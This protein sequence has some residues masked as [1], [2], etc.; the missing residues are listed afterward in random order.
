MARDS[1]RQPGVLGKVHAAINRLGLEQVNPASWAA[2]REPSNVASACLDANI[3]HVGVGSLLM[4]ANVLHVLRGDAETAREA[5]WE[6]LSQPVEENPSASCLLRSQAIIVVLSHGCNLNGLCSAA[7]AAYVALLSVEGA[8]QSW[9]TLFQPLAFQSAMSGLR[10]LQR[11]ERSPTFEE[12]GKDLPADDEFFDCV[13]TQGTTQHEAAELLLRLLLVFFR[14]RPLQSSHDIAALAIGELSALVLQPKEDCI[15]QTA[16]DVLVAVLDGAHHPEE[17]RRIAIVILRSLLPALLMTSSKAEMSQGIVSKSTL[18]ARTV[19]LKLARDIIRGNSSLLIRMSAPTPAV[20]QTISDS[21]V[22]GD[23]ANGEIESRVADIAGSQDVLKQRLQQKGTDEPVLA[24]LQLACVSVPD[25]AEWRTSAVEAVL[26]ILADA[27]AE[28][29]KSGVRHLLDDVKADGGNGLTPSKGDAIGMIPRFLVFLNKLLHAER[30]PFRVFAT[31]L[32][33]TMMEQSAA[34]VGAADWCGMDGAADAARGCLC[35]HLLEALA[36]RCEDAMPIVRSHAVSGVAAGVTALSDNTEG[37][38]LLRLALHLET[39]SADTSRVNLPKLFRSAARDDKAFT[40]RASILLFEACMRLAHTSLGLGA[41]KLADHFQAELIGQ[42]SLDDSVMVRKSSISSFS[43]LLKLCPTPQVCMLWAQ[44][45]LPLVLDVEGGVVERALEEVEFAVV[46]PLMQKQH[47]A[48]HADLQR[49][50]DWDSALAVVSKPQLPVVLNYLDSESTEY[51]QRA[52]RCFSVR[53]QAAFLAP[54]TESLL[55]IIQD[56]LQLPLSQWPSA[57]WSLLEELASSTQSKRVPADL[58]Y[59]SWLCAESEKQKEVANVDSDSSSM[60]RFRHSS[61][62][63]QILNVLENVASRLSM[64]QAFDL[65]S[66]LRQRLS[67]LTLPTEQVQMALRVMKRLEVLQLIPEDHGLHWRSEFLQKIEQRLAQSVRH[68]EFRGAGELHGYLVAVGE[69]A[70]LEEATISEGIVH[71]LQRIVAGTATA[72][73]DSASRSHALAALGKLCLRREALAKRLVELFVLHLGEHEPLAVRNNAVIVL[74]DLCV[75]YTALVDRFVPCMANLLRDSSE[76][77]RKQTVMVFAFLLSESF[78]KFRGCLMYRILYVLSDPAEEI[79]DL[80]ECL[81]THILHKRDPAVFT[82]NFVGVICVFNGWFGHPKYQSAL[83]NEQFSLV[84]SP[85]RRHM[86]YRFMLSLMSQ[87]Q[88][89]NVCA[90]LVT[91]F[92]SGFADSEEQHR[93]QLPRSEAEPGG[94]VLSDAFALLCCKE[95]K[96]MRVCFSPKLAGQDED[97]TGESG[98]MD[99]EAARSTFAGLLRKVIR[100]SIVP[101]LVQLKDLMEE[102]RSPFLGRLRSCLCEMVRE[103][104]DDLQHVLQGDT[105]LAEEVAYDLG[106]HAAFLLPSTEGHGKKDATATLDPEICNRKVENKVGCCRRRIS[107]R[108]AMNASIVQ[109]PLL[110]SSP[111]AETSTTDGQETALS[112][113]PGAAPSASQAS[114]AQTMVRRNKAPHISAEPTALPPS[115]SQASSAQTVVQLEKTQQINAEPT[116][117]P[118]HR[119]LL[120]EGRSKGRLKGRQKGHLL[121]PA[122]KV[123]PETSLVLASLEQEFQTAEKNA[124]MDTAPA[125]PRGLMKDSAVGTAANTP[126][127]RAPATP[128]RIS[129]GPGLV[130]T[131][132]AFHAA[133][134]SSCR[135]ETHPSPRSCRAALGIG[136]APNP[137]SSSAKAQRGVPGALGLVQLLEMHSRT[138]PTSSPAH[139][140][141]G[142]I[143]LLAAAEP[144]SS[145]AHSGNGSIGLLAAAELHSSPAHRG[146]GSIGLLA[147]VELHSRSV[148][149]RSM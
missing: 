58:I 137:R 66:S 102:E 45:L 132:L 147:A 18:N 94:Q 97:E 11:Q 16:A 108:S 17:K 131:A 30:V 93:L 23:I 89:F 81:F 141:N 113:Q 92:L 68:G 126:A 54:L 1:G 144:H 142:R 51:L 71:S 135:S 21:D 32:A 112:T 43:L 91:G 72:G 80:V 40:K 115:V 10:V 24:L 98:G 84:D 100:E 106:L 49:T 83:S 148:R 12:H 85:Q 129:P 60:M 57:V 136:P 26:L 86:I 149:R 36:A 104:K 9:G 67:A 63:V 90:Q 78:V 7:G 133:T 103:F 52:M 64:P 28:Q 82:H 41:E 134:S 120:S 117:S 118:I 76:I 70:L 74:G 73:A 99:A 87:E 111:E 31:D 140:G 25:R 33:A 39:S 105:R 122:K 143:G 59:K 56:S 95:L 110:P 75:H 14:S 15:T 69:L 123:P 146:N 35:E 77:L 96:E 114:S 138:P 79:R 101:I 65:S 88:K 3:D 139:R 116:A 2:L 38:E 62:G 8:E 20:N 6:W 48:S 128:Q 55:S 125:T 107:L 130:S 61:L 22:E 109:L 145:P 50:P 47:L 27:V 19:A 124:M 5:F 53:H 44:H 42:L 127:E 46:R 119:E 34:L 121:G 13:D 37:L 4:L 29:T